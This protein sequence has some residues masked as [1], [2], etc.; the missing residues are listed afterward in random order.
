MKYPK[1]LIVTFGCAMATLA[2]AMSHAMQA[3]SQDAP[4]S[5]SNE[6]YLTAELLSRSSQQ[7]VTTA[8]T[9]A[10]DPGVSVDDQ[11]S[12]RQRTNTDAEDRPKLDLMFEGDRLRRITIY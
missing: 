8:G 2:P 4:A 7:I 12:F 3:L 11:R 9:F 10:L 1:V 6:R 5:S